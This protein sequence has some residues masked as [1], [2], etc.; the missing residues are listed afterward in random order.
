M[1]SVALPVALAGL[2]AA[3]AWWAVGTLRLRRALGAATVADTALLVAALHGYEGDQPRPLFTDPLAKRLA[4]QR[5][6]VDVQPV[7]VEVAHHGPLLHRFDGEGH[8][9]GID[10]GGDAAF[11]LEGWGHVGL[12]EGDRSPGLSSSAEG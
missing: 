12:L 9:D 3:L 4:G 1:A 11:E 8:D 5:G 7:A 6:A 2:A 10:P